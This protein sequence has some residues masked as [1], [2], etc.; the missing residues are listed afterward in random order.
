MWKWVWLEDLDSRAST[1]ESQHSNN[2]SSSLPPP[3]PDSPDVT[4]PSESD[5]SDDDSIPVIT[6]AVIFKCIGVHKERRYQEILS[7]A[8]TRLEDGQRVPVKLYPEPDNP[9]DSKAIAFM[10][11]IVDS[12]WER[13]GYAVS[14]VLDELHD[15]I[16]GG[17]IISVSFDYIKYSV[18]FSKL[19]WYAGIRISRSGEWSSKVLRS[20]A[21]SYNTF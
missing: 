9:V 19:G 15:A 3:P 16:S 18:H 14:E 1:P 13:I 20:R 7:E 21:A 5:E 17:K 10:C 8:S 4:T 2:S 6:H 12:A 11:Q